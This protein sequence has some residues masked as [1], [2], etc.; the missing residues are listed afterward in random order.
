MRRALAG[1]GVPAWTRVTGIWH[2]LG[3]GNTNVAGYREGGWV[4]P[5]IAPSRYTHPVLPTGPHPADRSPYTA[6]AE[7]A[8]H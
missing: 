8:G 2:W 7:A 6:D 3:P 4:V 1:P 5:G